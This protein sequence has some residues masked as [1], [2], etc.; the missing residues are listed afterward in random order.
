MASPIHQRLR[1]D[2][3]ASVFAPDEPL[4]EAKLTERYGASRT[5]VRE[6]LQRLE[7][8]GL[9]ERRGKAVVVRTHSAEEIIDIY[10]SRIILEQ[11]AAAKAAVKATALDRQL[12]TGLLAQMQQLDPNDGRALAETN[13]AFHAQ[14]W[15]AT[16]SPSLIGLLERLD[17]QV[18]RYTLT[19]LTYPGRWPVVLADYAELLAAIGDGDSKRAGEIAARHMSDALDIRLKMYAED[20]RTL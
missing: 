3:L 6:A 16:H 17:Q 20:P 11:A 10:E 13:R 2:V 4:T 12:L 5:P 9:V 19:T 1:E 14:L 7:Q 15:H 18:R 8:D